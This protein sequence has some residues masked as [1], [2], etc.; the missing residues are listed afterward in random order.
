[1]KPI[2]IV[3]VEDHSVLREALAL[4]LN[5]E[6]GFTITGHWGSAEEMLAH[7]SDTPFDIAILDRMLPGMDGLELTGKIKGHNPRARVVMLS[8]V[9]EEKKILEAFEN[10][11]DGYLTKEAPISELIDAIKGTFDGQKIVG[12]GLTASLIMF[13]SRAKSDKEEKSPLTDGQ[14]VMLNLAAEG[15][16]NKEIALKLDVPLPNV[17]RRFREIFTRLG[18]RHRTH[19]IVKAAKMGLISI[20]KE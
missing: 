10:G 19:A 20:H 9:T 18:A 15:M 16:T 3:I 1:M 4:A 17:K 5:L 12:R 6:K 13:L 14:M 8:M 7:M 2:R 11:V